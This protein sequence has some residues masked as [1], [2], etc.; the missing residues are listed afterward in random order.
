LQVGPIIR[1][2]LFDGAA[3]YLLIVIHHL[4]VDAVS[5]GVLLE[6]LETA[7]RQ[8]AGGEQVSLPPKT[9]SFKT[10]AEE[11]TRFARS[12]TIEKEITYWT[13]RIPQAV[14]SLPVDRSGSNTVASRRTV[15]VSLTADET[16][17]ILHELPTK[18]R[19]QINEV[20]LAALTRTFTGW[21][22]T[23][24][25][26]IDLE[27]HGRE[28]LVEGVDLTRTV[29]WFTTIFPV[30]FDIGNSATPLEVLRAVK[31]Q[32][33]AIPNRG[34]GYGLLRY[35]SG[36]TDV[37]DELARSPQAEVRFNYLGQ[38][39]RFLAPSNLF[40]AAQHTSGQAQSP[41]DQ[42]GYLLNIISSVTNGE[43]HFHWTYSENIHT[44]KIIESQAETCLAELRAL[45]SDSETSG[46]VYAPTDFPKANLSQSD[47]NAIL[48][49]LRT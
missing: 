28:H 13:S 38:L 17:A 22:R 46:A 5:W 14:V 2:A 10:W 18:H 47:L 27:G 8:L 43:L 37:I 29:G 48:A 15:S 23:S 26:L 4:A 19:T 31:E 6:D 12:S 36:R 39:D 25:F 20:L 21:M 41:R 49:K 1:V 16:R 42:R 11:L 7:Y 9:T 32:L 34:I 44:K 40:D 3:G 24:S 45:L 33:R 35:S 30:V